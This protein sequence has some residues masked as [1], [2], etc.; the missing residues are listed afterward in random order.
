MAVTLKIEEKKKPAAHVEPAPDLSDF[1]A[2]GERGE[3]TK[4]FLIWFVMLLLGSVILY[5]VPVAALKPI[6]A[7]IGAWWILSVIGYMFIAPMLTLRRL[8]LDDDSRITA[9]TQPRLANAIAKGSAILGVPEPEAYLLEEGI[10]QVKI[11]G[12][13]PQF[14]TIT[15]AATELLSPNELDALILRAL[16]HSRENHVRRLSL[17]Q[18]LADTPPIA[19]FLAWPISFYAALLN[20]AWHEL[21][22][23]TADRLAL[24]ILRNPKIFMAAMLK[25][26]AESD[27]QMREIGITSED[28]DAYIQQ[29]G[30]ID[31][32]GHSVSTQYKIGSAIG[33]NP[34]IEAR[35]AAFNDWAKSPEFQTALAKMKKPAA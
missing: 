16:V 17:L 4:A 28:V 12:S 31:A 11:L 34:Y 21:A 32:A 23:Q 22:E 3:G 27:P 26:L 25:Q 30:R 29:D 18:F 8:R 20:M 13:A 1:V 33:D 9:K 14:L 2:E 10:S 35:I 6:G 15:K 19:R 5:L 24:I 7:G